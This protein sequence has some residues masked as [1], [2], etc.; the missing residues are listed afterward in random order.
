MVD[1]MFKGEFVGIDEI[2]VS[3]DRTGKQIPYATSRALN[4]LAKNVDE[5][6]RR[7]MGATF[8]R[9]KPQTV[10]ATYVKRSTKQNLSVEIGI[11]NRSQ[12]VPAAEYL[13][14]N[15]GASGRKARN[16][17]RSEFMLQRAGLLPP[18]L[19]TVPGSGA[20]LD[21]WGNMSRGQIVQIL[22]YFRTFGNSSL[23]S[24][25]MNITAKTR[26]RFAKTARQYFVVPVADKKLGLFPGIW[27]ETA[28]RK[29][30]PILLFVKQPIYNAIYDFHGTALKVVHATFQKEF[31]IALEN[32][33]RTAR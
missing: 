12:G 16:Y 21:Q 4:A 5:E 22:S 23:N 3:I 7:K 15:I 28:G 11:K 2:R 6:E 32:A 14:A 29:L 26:A 25:R 27:Q 20:R 18:G 31:D 33:L 1:P 9:P 24:K 19:F 10:K 13:N 8:D 30:S 17:K